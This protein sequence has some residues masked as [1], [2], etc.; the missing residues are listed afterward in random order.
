MDVS[1][2]AAPVVTTI[3]A[4][5]VTAPNGIVYDG[6]NNR[7]I[8]VNWGSNA[9][10][11]AVDLSNNA[12]STLTT[13][14]VG[15]IDGIDDDN[16]GHYYISS[17][18]PARIT[19][20][21]ASFTGTPV[22]ITAPGLSSPADIGYAKPIDTLAIPNGN[23]TV[24]FIGFTPVGI[25]ETGRTDFNLNLSPNPVSENSYFSFELDNAKKVVLK[26]FDDSGKEVATLL[27]ER[28]NAGKHYLLLSGIGLTNGNYIFSF[29]VDD[30]T[31][32]GKFVKM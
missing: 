32:S 5:T 22:T 12:V 21:D 6:T 18:S 1:N 24:T 15:N 19:R 14:T 8:F 27:N 9:P 13:T 2:L 25:N 23:N 10:I 7:L 16:Y 29:N 11:K 30:K 4:N 3:V 31:I 17:W 28:L 26:I 20:F